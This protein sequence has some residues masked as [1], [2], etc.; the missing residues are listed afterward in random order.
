MSDTHGWI[1]WLKSTRRISSFKSGVNPTIESYNTSAV[2]VYNIISSL[3]HFQNKNMI[4]HSFK[5]LQPM[6]IQQR[7]RCS[8]KC[9]CCRI[10]S[11]TVGVWIGKLLQLHITL[12]NVCGW[13][14]TIGL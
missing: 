11:W 5:T 1:K 12:A 8:C 7:W 13:E 2:K 6:Y 4:F 14:G 3:V 10:G 9:N